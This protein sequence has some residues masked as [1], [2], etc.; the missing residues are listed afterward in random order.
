M[1]VHLA[2]R[3]PVRTAERAPGPD[4]ARGF[5]LVLIAL[6]NTA[7][8]LWAAE[9]GTTSIHPA[10][11]SA[12]D[13]IVQAVLI[14]TVDMR[15]YPMFAFLFGYGLVQIYR[16]QT[17]AG[18]TDRAAR[19]LLRRRNL[20]LLAFGSVHAALLWM[21]DVLGAYGFAGL[22][23]VAIFFRRQDK[24]LRIWATVLI[25]VSGVV[26][27]MS[28]M[29]AVF[30]AG[31]PAPETATPNFLEMS[32][33]SLADPS[34]LSS[35][36][37]RLLFWPVLVIGQGLITGVIPIVLLLAFWAAR[38]QILERPGDHL[39]L[40]RRT[41]IIGIAIGWIG[42][43]PHA[44]YHVG[45]WAVPDHASWVFNS[46]Q[47]VTGLFAGVGYVAVFGLIG[48]RV[49]AGPSASRAGLTGVLTAVGRRSLSCYLAQSL[50][51]APLLSAWGLGLGARMGSAGMAGFAIAVWAVIAAGAW[52]LERQGRP[53]PA[54]WLL[55]RLIYGAGRPP[56]N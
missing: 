2:P 56:V 30:V 16:R 49:T 19:R 24:T 8:Y 22:I 55:R 52:L 20:W 13:R 15:V 25:A 21:G 39:P 51:C 36:V 34:Y 4:L 37:N 12:L 54:E 45:L 43:V 6:A 26:L 27:L 28:I 1:T 14:T 18:A 31:Q 35:L 10:E 53:G 38:H 5:M 40:L 47:P 11:G 17:A 33:V 29:G 7:W 32:R 41:A 46:S 3:G 9:P 50:I 23:M 48:H 44:L 42:G